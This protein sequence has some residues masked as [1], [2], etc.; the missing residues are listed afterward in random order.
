MFV[1]T[2]Y[3]AAMRSELPRSVNERL[4]ETAIE[5]FGRKGREAASTRLIATAAGTA[6]SSIT[7]HYGGK[8][9]LYLA[10]ARHIAKEQM[11]AG[12]AGAL[13]KAALAPDATPTQALEGIYALAEGMLAMLLDPRCA[14]WARFIVRE[15]MEPTAA[16]E[17]LYE[18]VIEKVAGRLVGLI[19]RVGQGRWSA[20]EARLKAVTLFGQILVFRVACETVARVTGWKEIDSERAARIALVVRANCRA[21]LETDTSEEDG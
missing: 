18:A 5:Q 13:E 17:I 15:Q 14:A 20:E 21:I 7:Y 12:L 16:F 11:E 19:E 9:G 8:E 2:N 3:N 4:L 10:A 1:R 6:M